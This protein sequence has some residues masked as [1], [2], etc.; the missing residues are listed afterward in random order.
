MSETSRDPE[1]LRVFISYSREDLGFADQLVVT[2]ELAGFVPT[3]DRVGISGAEAWQDKLGTLIRESDTVVFVLSPA[4]AQS[5]V[6]GW[7]VDEA[8][9]M[10][11]RIIPVLARPLGEVAVPT[12]LAA[13]NYIFFYAEPSRPSSGWASGMRELDKALRTDLGWLREHTRLLQRAVEWEAGGK[14][15]GRL[16]SG[17]DILE[18]RAWVARQPR[19]APAPTASHLAFI[20]ASEAWQQEQASERERALAERER[21]V[22]EA[23]ASRAER[24]QAQAA[25]LAAAKREAAAQRRVAQRTFVGLVVASVL[26][27]LACG[28]GWWAFEKQREAVAERERAEDQSRRA[29]DQRKRAEEE[30]RRAEA[31]KAKAFDTAEVASSLFS[32]MSESSSKFAT[33]EARDQALFYHLLARANRGIVAAQIYVGVL[34]SVGQG[35]VQDY[36]QA[37]KWFERA[38]AQGDPE[39]LTSLGGLYYH[40]NGVE[41]DYA[42]AFSL[43]EKAAAAGSRQ[44]MYN[45]GQLYSQAK[46][47]ARDYGRAREWYEK[48]AAAGDESAMS[49]LGQLFQNGWGVVRDYGKA[50]EWYEKAANA[51]KIGALS[52]IGLHYA[53]GLG[54]ERDYTKAR[55][56]Y[57]KS[58]VTGDTLGMNNI[59]GLY[60][61]GHGVAQDYDKAR[62][63]YEKAAAGG[64][65]GSMRN[66]ALLYEDGLGV[67][68]DYIKAR[69]WY[70]KA[71]AAGDDASLI[72]LGDMYSRGLG[73]PQNYG[74]A[75]ELWEKA[76]SAGEATAMRNV[77][78]LYEK[79]LGTTRNYSKALEWFEKAVSAGN[80]EAMLNIGAMHENGM[81]M[82]VNSVAAREWFEKAASAGIVVAMLKIGSMYANGIG[83]TQSDEKAREWWIK[84]ARSGGDAAKLVIRSSMEQAFE[85]GGFA[86]A[87]R[88]QEALVDE[89]EESETKS[90]GKPGERTSRELVGLAWY[91]LFVRQPL[92]ALVAAERALELWSQDLSAD[93]NRAHALLFLGRTAEA[94]GIYLGHKDKSLVSH[95]GKLWQ[96][97]ISE[98]FAALRE[99]RLDHPQMPEIEQALGI[100]KP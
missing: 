6:C 82:P 67:A 8:V 14:A 12:A 11:K 2:L 91:S 53:L 56:Y 31:E 5:R 37:F 87:L 47:V 1:K 95:G 4:S 64:N 92:K 72:N 28:A 13:L 71:A 85:T 75:L 99:A 51:G 19:A 24:E 16:L 3:I 7:E 44:A 100:P 84:A 40:G 43:Y 15:T 58:T 63:W 88:L 59:G 21:L 23:D 25:V 46:G 96:Q 62:D 98:D 76:A 89:T 52:D 54:V 32:Q 20:A 78:L 65:A 38:A 26:A 48:A 68:Q 60:Q 17:A 49:N 83:A 55:E 97:V 29:L 41:L 66:L 30:Q 90:A 36:N 57:E 27:V 70:Q 77:G 45:L 69:E 79:G 39:A 42:K 9:A 50:R 93:T 33:R 34:Y 86:D 22:R 10:G 61:Y 81:G 73:V 35:V 94:R 18:A 74:K 80:I